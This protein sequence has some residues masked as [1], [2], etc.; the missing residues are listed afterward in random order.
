ME[1]AG[2]EEFRMPQGLPEYCQ[3][4]KPDSPAYIILKDNPVDS[5]HG[6]LS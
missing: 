4:I 3:P 6:F 1:G 2:P 5:F